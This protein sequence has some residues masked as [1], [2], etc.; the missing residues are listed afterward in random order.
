V[1]SSHV[2]DTL[3]LFAPQGTL[4]TVSKDAHGGSKVTLDPPHA[5]T[6]ASEATHH[7]GG[8]VQHFGD[9]LWIG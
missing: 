9:Y 6:F 7:L 5:A 1:H 4:F 2:T 8:S 3:R